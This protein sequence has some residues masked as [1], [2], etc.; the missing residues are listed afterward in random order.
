MASLQIRDMPENVYAALAERA[1]RERRSLAQQAVVEL[2][3]VEEI[4]KRRQR[5]AAVEKLRR[6]E[7]I[8]RLSDPVEIIRQD[9]DR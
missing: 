8:R 7:P 3:Q 2:S 1:R 9:R 6:M 5:L 4:G